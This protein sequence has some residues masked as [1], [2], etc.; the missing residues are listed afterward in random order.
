MN[1]RFVLIF[2]FETTGLPKNN[3]EK[4]EIITTYNTSKGIIVN[5]SNEKDFPY[6]VQLSYILYDNLLHKSKIVDEIIRLPEGVEITPES[7]DIHKISL[8]MTQ[9]KNRKVKNKRT[10]RFRKQYHLTIDEVLLKFMKDF[11]KADIIVSHNILFDKNMLL[12]E[13]DRLRNL[14]NKK[15]SIFEKY[16]SEIYYNKKEFCT[17][18]NGRNTCKILSVNKLGK[19]YYKMP[20]L[21]VLYE[22]LFREKP[23]ESKLHNALYDVLL[24][25]RCFY[26]MKYNI[27]IIEYDNKIKELLI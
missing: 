4:Y 16:I 20:K 13:M 11:E 9:G 24:C 15:Y 5:P 22:Y 18:I 27:D 2:D 26:K 17:A 3:W 21:I 25:M 7:L 14:P 23:D 6:A 8:S 12:V 10:G 1:E 19:E